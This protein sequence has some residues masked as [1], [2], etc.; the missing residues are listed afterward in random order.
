M[1]KT[2]RLTRTEIE[3]TVEKAWQE[4]LKTSS[5]FKWDPA[6][7]E[8][9]LKQMNVPRET[10]VIHGL[11]IGTA[12]GLGGFG[13]SLARNIKNREQLDQVLREI[14]RA[15]EEMPTIFRKAAKQMIATLPRRG[16]P[17]RK[18][19][20]NSR[21]ASQMCDQIVFFIRQKNTLKQ[22]LQKAAELS[23][24]IIG[25]KKVGSRTLQKAWDQRDKLTGE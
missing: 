17:G 11:T 15:G 24:S 2:G 4:M 10:L 7:V 14:A 23:P 5:T 20:L 1:K 3:R 16:G 18:P 6:S 21:E 12:L 22:A 9:E 13:K 8:T 19:K 25:G